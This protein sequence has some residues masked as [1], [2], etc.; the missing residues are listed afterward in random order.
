MG[1]NLGN[2][3]PK[4]PGRILKLGADNDSTAVTKLQLRLKELGCGDLA[5]TGFFGIKTDEAVRLFQARFTDVDG[6]PLEVDGEVGA[7]TWGA[8]FGRETLPVEETAPTSLMEE[9]LKFAV[10]QIGVMEKPLGS[11]KGEQVEKYLRSV[12]L[13]GGFAWCMAFV[14]WC[15]QQAAEKKGL[16]NPL[17]KTGGVLDHWN[18]AKNIRRI[19]V[20]DAKNNPSLVRPGMIFI[21]D[22]GTPG[23]A[24]HG[25]F[26]EKMV[27]GKLITI[28]GNTNDSGAR[29]GIGVFRRQGRKIA[30]INKG[31]L[32][33]SK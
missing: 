28:E 11:N 6:R 12:G 4:Y 19:S 16:E 7:I 24:G 25:A 15:Y 8:I 29:E 33:Y 13:G 21:I 9:A 27:G 17:V 3:S 5:G 26:V 23:G 14:Y 2:E 32:D 30:S 22:T 31:F 18:R 10:S 20:Q 1:I